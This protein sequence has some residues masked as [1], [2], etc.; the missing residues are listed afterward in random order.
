MKVIKRGIVN[1]H[2]LILSLSSWWRENNAFWFKLPYLL[3]LIHHMMI[4]TGQSPPFLLLCY[5][6]M[7]DQCIGDPLLKI[8]FV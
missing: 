3:I 1:L 5:F 7:Q 2:I 4:P 8:C 6:W